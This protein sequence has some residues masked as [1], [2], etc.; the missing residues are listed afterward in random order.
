MLD[1]YVGF[2]PFP[3]KLLKFIVCAWQTCF[4]DSNQRQEM[5]AGLADVTLIT[6][7]PPIKAS[8]S[9]KEKKLFVCN[10]HCQFC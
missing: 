9:F 7:T 1:I 5:S 3:T 4:E 6:G 10:P 8:G 2:N